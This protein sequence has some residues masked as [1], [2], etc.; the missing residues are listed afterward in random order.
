MKVPKTYT[1]SDFGPEIARSSDKHRVIDILT[2]VMEVMAA[3][4]PAQLGFPFTINR[5][6]LYSSLLKFTPEAYDLY[7]ADGDGLANTEAYEHLLNEMVV[8]AYN[9]SWSHVC[10]TNRVP[11]PSDAEYTVGLFLANT[12]LLHKQASQYSQLTR[13]FDH[14]SVT[15]GAP[16]PLDVLD[17]KVKD[18]TGIRAEDI[19]GL[20]E[21]EGFLAKNL[22]DGMVTIHNLANVNECIREVILDLMH[23]RLAEKP[24]Q[25]RATLEDL[26]DMSAAREE[27]DQDRAGYTPNRPGRTLGRQRSTDLENI[28]QTLEIMEKQLH[29]ATDLLLGI[30]R[31]NRNK[32]Y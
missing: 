2:S 29:F 15:A 30:A 19:A 23:K 11:L 5:A 22:E 7:I 25:S 28:H 31:P 20:I 8:H 27:M 24:R 32:Q 14:L 10:F 18:I 16:D 21:F 1:K 17:Q 13:S 9:L 6:G 12:D 3:E 26:T 4:F